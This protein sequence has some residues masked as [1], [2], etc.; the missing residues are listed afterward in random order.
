MQSFAPDVDATDARGKWAWFLAYGI[1]LVAVGIIA[2]GNVVSATLVT[3][4]WL[5]WLLMFGGIVELISAFTYP[6]SLGGRI[7]H[8]VL[9]LLYIAVGI[10]LAFNPIT[11]AITVAAVVAIMLIAD[12]VLRLWFAL[13]TNA[14]DRWLLALLGIIDVL[15]GVWL[16]TNIPVSALAVGFY[17]GFMLLVAGVS[18]IVLAFRVRSLP[19]GA[20]GA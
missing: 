9:G 16:W 14:A 20:G 8:V 4:I 7:L 1:L 10:Q 2:L 5:G 19:E 12:G 17:V 6:R 11:G 13:T 18:W 15:L 3:T